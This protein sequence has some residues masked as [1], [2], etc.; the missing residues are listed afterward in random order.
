M[1]TAAAHA[2]PGKFTVM[3]SSTAL[4]LEKHRPAV[5]AACI[6]AG[7]FPIWM[8][9]LPARDADGVKVSLEMVDKADLYIGVYAWRY[10][11][12][13][14]GGDKSITELEF[15]HAVQCKADGKLHELLIFTAHQE[16]PCTAKDVEA[17]KDA[18]QKLAAF[19][20]R[21]CEGRGKKDFSSVEELQR[22][23][24]EALPHR[25]DD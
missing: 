25:R 6:G 17:D 16:H 8:K 3:I 5:E 14:K 9:H 21:A 7:V 11:W 19:K 4:D 1:T 18:Q 20:T 10:G 13:P 22:L 2:K 23:V 24:S 15:D 12:V